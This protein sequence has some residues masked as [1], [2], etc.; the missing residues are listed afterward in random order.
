MNSGRPVVV[1]LHRQ[2]LYD[3]VWSR[4]CTQIAASLGISSSALKRICTAM[5]IPTPSV[6]HWTQMQFGKS[7]A[8]AALPMAGPK[9]RLQWQVDL[10]N[11]LSQKHSGLAITAPSK[12][13]PEGCARQDNG[14]QIQLAKDLEN[15]HPLVKATRAQWRESRG[16]TPWEKRQ[17]RK[18]FNASVSLTSEER[19]LILLD[20]FARG[21]EAAGV[22]FMCSLDLGMKKSDNPYH[23]TSGLCWAQV[24]DE[25]ISFS[26]RERNRRVKLDP[27]QA[28]RDY[29]DWKEEPSGLLVFSI[30]ASWNFGHPTVWNDG[31]R[32][33][34]E[35]KLSEIVRTLQ[36]I[37]DH[38][39]DEKIRQQQ[40][41]ERRHIEEQ[42]RSRIAQQRDRMNEQRKKE[43]VAL[44]KAIQAAQSWQKAGLLRRYAA[45]MDNKLKTESETLDPNSP[46]MMYLQWLSLRADLLDPFSKAHGFNPNLLAREV[47]GI[48]A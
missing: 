27:A 38:K 46:A 11:S 29:R 28:K 31:K 21:A 1:V 45:A 30:E 36:L 44:D 13:A 4:P 2:D 3:D 25:R 5:D 43:E 23:H 9:T 40:E 24:G 8:K 19:V 37:H 48:L 41:A 7:V 16:R 39:R 47:P 12:D 14:P 20:G 33:K 17:D 22:Q 32:Q 34:I 10:E 26:L 35:E 15:L 6:G 18:R 42:R